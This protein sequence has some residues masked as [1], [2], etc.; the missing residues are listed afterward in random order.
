MARTCSA[1]GASLPDA[2]AF[3]AS[4]GTKW[5]AAAEAHRKVCVGCGSPLEA[6]TKFCA[7]C[8]MAVQGVAAAPVGGGNYAPGVAA[9]SAVAPASMATAAAQKAGGGAVKVIV[10]VLG[11]F[12]FAGLLGM[13]SCV[14]IAYRAKQKVEGLKEQYENNDANKYASALE[15][16][17]AKSGESSS[18]SSSSAGSPTSP[19]PG[20]GSSADTSAAASLISMAASAMSGSKAGDTTPQP[21]LPHWKSYAGSPVSGNSALVPLKV[22]LMEVGAVNDAPLGDY[23]AI[24]TVTQIEKDGVVIS[25]SSEAPPPNSTG[26]GGGKVA[27][28]KEFRGM[29]KH[30]KV[31]SEDIA[32][33]HELY[34]YFGSTDPYTFPGT[35]SETVSREVF[36][37]LK[38]KGESA[39]S[40]KVFTVQGALTGLLD[41]MTNPKPGE[42]LDPQNLTGSLMTKINCTLAKAEANDVGFPVI[43]ND[44]PVELPAIHATC[45]SDQDEL[46]LWILDDAQ[47][48]IDLAF[49]TKLGKGRGQV[50]KINFPED[51]PVNHIEQALKQTGH[52]QIYGIN[53]DFASATIRPQSQPILAEIAKAMKDNPAWKVSVNGHTDNIG[54]DASNL[55]LSRKRAAAV[56]EALTSQ[57]RIGANRF[58]SAGFGASQPIDTNDTIEGRA[59]N[60]R[61]ELVLQ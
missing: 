11:L 36:N 14:Y 33:A 2:Q 52:A 35:T 13:G 57:Y 51:H 4:C 32:S 54:G 60:R 20:A 46:H 25:I 48:P 50:V 43:M 61:V 40:Y 56:V 22:G 45:K 21:E 39:F 24:V 10:T 5:V 3:C 18:S 58:T 49:S 6:G 15:K 17:M 59:R 44:K 41:K 42:T 53:F 47:N 28:A 8:G 37:E 27:T 29:E 23:E 34:F 16:Q 19:S 12:M 26:V 9:S 38:S 7:K 30:R 1:C 55:E 31:L